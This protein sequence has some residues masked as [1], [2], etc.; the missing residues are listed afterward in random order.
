MA[1]PAPAAAAESSTNP[2]P[3]KETLVALIFIFATA[4]CAT[5]SSHTKVSSGAPAPAPVSPSTETTPTRR[6]T[7]PYTFT[8]RGVQIRVNSI[9]SAQNQVLVSV[10]LQEMR[11]ESV[12]ILAATLT[13]VVTTAGQ[14][15][16][17]SQYSRADKVQNDPAIHLDAHDQFS[18]TLFF[19]PAAG[20]AEAESPSLELRF[21]TGKYWNSSA[22]E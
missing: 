7:L 4:G 17:Y 21:P 20:A 1:A 18:I 15:L 11:G 3:L 2:M 16:T 14:T 8:R 19:K 22:A 12:D 6:V 5:Q 10:T 13:Q 9:E